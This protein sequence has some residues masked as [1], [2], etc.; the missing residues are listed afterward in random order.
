[1]RATYISLALGLIGCLLVSA[2]EIHDAYG[3]HVANGFE[4]KLGE[5]DPERKSELTVELSHAERLDERKLKSLTTKTRT[6]RFLDHSITRTK[7]KTV[8]GHP[9]IHTAG[10]HEDLEDTR[11]EQLQFYPFVR[12]P[13]EKNLDDAT[14]P[15][16]ILSIGHSKHN[17]PTTLAERRRADNTDDPAYDF[18][19]SHAGRDVVLGNALTDA[20]TV[21][22]VYPASDDRKRSAKNPDLRKWCLAHPNACMKDH[23][24]RVNFLPETW[25]EIC[26]R[27]SRLCSDLCR[28]GVHEACDAAVSHEPRDIPD[29]SQDLRDKLDSAVAELVS[30]LESDDD[31][32]SHANGNHEPTETVWVEATKVAYTASTS[33]P[34]NRRSES[35][36]HLED[37][38]DRASDNIEDEINQYVH[39]QA[40]G[41]A[42][43]VPNFLCPGPCTD[44]APF[45]AFI[46]N[47]AVPT[48]GSANKRQASKQPGYV[49]S[50]SD[51]GSQ[52]KTTL[53]P[54]QVSDDNVVTGT[55][56]IDQPRPSGILTTDKNGQPVYVTRTG[57]WAD[58]TVTRTY[59]DDG[60]TTVTLYSQFSIS[61]KPPVTVTMI[62]HDPTRSGTLIETVDAEGS[63]VWVTKTGVFAMSTT[64]VAIPSGLHSN[65][66]GASFLSTSETV[67]SQPTSASVAP[68]T[69]TVTRVTTLTD[70]MIRPF[71]C[72]RTSLDFGLQTAMMANISGFSTPV[73]ITKTKQGIGN[74]TVVVALP[75]PQATVFP[76]ST[77]QDF[78]YDMLALM[79]SR[80]M[81]EQGHR[82]ILD[83]DLSSLHDAMP[84][85]DWFKVAELGYA[86]S[87][88]H[89]TVDHDMSHKVALLWMLER[90]EQHAQHLKNVAV[91]TQAPKLLEARKAKSTQ[92]VATVTMLDYDQDGSATPMTVSG[93]DVGNRTVATAVPFDIP[94]AVQQ[95]PIPTPPTCQKGNDLYNPRKCRYQRCMMKHYKPIDI[96]TVYPAAILQDKGSDCTGYNYVT[97]STRLVNAHFGTTKAHQTYYPTKPTVVAGKR[98][99]QPTMSVVRQIPPGAARSWWHRILHHVAEGPTCWDQATCCHECCQ[100]TKHDPWKVIMWVLIGAGAIFTALAL[101]AAGCCGLLYRRHRRHQKENPHHSMLDYVPAAVPYFGRRNRRHAANAADPAAAG[102]SGAAGGAGGGQQAGQGGAGS[103]VDPALAAAAGAAAG[104]AL[105]EKHDDGAGQTGGADD[106]RGT[107]GR[108]AEEGRGKVAFADG[109]AAADAAQAG[110]QQ[111]IAT[112]P[113]GQQVITTTA[114]AA[115]A[116]AAE[117]S[118]AAPAEG[119]E[120]VVSSTPATAEQ[121]VTTTTPA[122]ATAEHVEPLTIHHD[123][124][125]DGIPTGR[126]VLDMGSMRGRKKNRNNTKGGGGQQQE[127]LLNI[128]RF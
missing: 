124:S 23:M 37:V 5:Y 18:E 55:T 30:W 45:E 9:H 75:Y 28:K 58:N 76:I 69:V 85:V 103:G 26:G 126:Q 117:K 109:G 6:D 34:L 4:D 8:N 22:D 64:T 35:D 67:D 99:R 74:G 17:W 62:S 42:V 97:Q 2:S 29:T 71:Q 73:P 105:S 48:P 96:I 11:M 47:G 16:D 102:K 77:Y 90:S 49:M 57:D 98:D 40:D 110:G 108:K 24:E 128:L 21:A 13:P 25:G 116:E 94:W 19:S 20:S 82:H 53:N 72:R 80:D 70:I 43:S 121:V 92:S 111:V 65:R 27:Y 78:V 10:N 36:G 127:D 115:P 51:M 14:A 33:L 54:P 7:T 113:S 39:N 112:T 83:S 56:N 119:A 120:K 89:A 93:F 68:Q 122:P 87:R 44:C 104:S 81:M 84:Y 125:S 52:G 31:N 38:L 107:M 100:K 66:T 1:M 106:G 60:S 61:K 101:A 88:H 118:I 86:I 41:E 123:G 95:S 46:G 59:E 79:E 50:I 91:V 32:A 114:A 3:L 15:V 12:P 63:S